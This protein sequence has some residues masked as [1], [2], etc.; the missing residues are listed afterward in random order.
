MERIIKFRV[1]DK[2][3][4]QMYNWS[5]IA[6]ISLVDFEREHYELMQFS[7]LYDKNKNTIYEGDIL[8]FGNKN[9]TQVTF[10]N[11]CFSVYNEPL[12]W[13]FDSEE[14]PIL[15]SNKYCEIIGNIYENPEL[16]IE[17]K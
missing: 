14:V 4:K 13:D 9:I 16:L 3:S 7:G 10:E 12:G 17:V 2:I 15:S 11:G 5:Q 8:Q 6:S 1:F